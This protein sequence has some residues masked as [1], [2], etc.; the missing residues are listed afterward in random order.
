MAQ[1]QN[2]SAD[3]DPSGAPAG[4]LKARRHAAQRRHEQLL[5]LGTN[6]HY[7]D[8]ELYDH[9]YADR[10]DDVRWYRALARQRAGDGEILELAAGSGRIACPLARDGHRVIALDRMPTMLDALR[11][12]TDGKS[13]AD[14]I[15]P[16]QADMRELPLP[17][18]SVGLV[19]AP[20]N[21]LMHL[22]TW[23]CLLAC[24]REVARVLPV[25]G[26]FAFDVML[27]DLEWLTWDPDERHAVTR[28]VHPTTRERLVY[29]T[30]HRYD[31]QTQVCHVRIYYDEAPPRGRKFVPPPEP[32]RTV[33]LAHRQIFPEELRM[34]VATAGLQLESLTGD[35]LE[36]PLRETNES[37]VAV[38][39]KP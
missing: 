29:S 36:A 2:G 23:Q 16:L 9:E 39:I 22:Y 20:F 4:G 28:F 35:F 5:T 1:R 34:L 24:F 19:I 30:N 26:T 6:D 11:R 18:A 8:T 17:D 10:L 32:K 7:E 38:C 15:S 21:G 25:G 37:Q 13:W 27:P 31:P 14:R 3:P 33:H 12:R